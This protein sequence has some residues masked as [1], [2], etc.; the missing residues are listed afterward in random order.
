MPA[1]EPRIRPAPT[2][3]PRILPG[4]AGRPRIRPTDPVA[5]TTPPPPDPFPATFEPTF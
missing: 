3:R 4:T 2:D 5:T 1:G